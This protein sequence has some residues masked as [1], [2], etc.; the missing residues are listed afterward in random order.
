MIDFATIAAAFQA[1]FAV[2]THGWPTLFDHMDKL[3]EKLDEQAGQAER[4]TRAYP[5]L[6]F[7]DDAVGVRLVLGNQPLFVD[8]T[9]PARSLGEGLSDG[10]RQFAAGFGWV[11]DAVASELALPRTATALKE[12][13]QAVDASLQRYEQPFPAMFDAGRHLVDVFGMAG[14]AWRALQGDQN[15]DQIRGAAL[16]AAAALDVA[17]ALTGGDRLAASATGGAGGDLTTPVERLV[18]SLEDAA[19]LTMDAVLLLPVAGLALD[20]ALTD[21]VLAVETAML[22]AFSGLEAGVYD[23]RAGVVDAWLRA[24]ALGT[25]VHYLSAAADLVATLDVLLLSSAVPLWLNNLLDGVEAVLHGLGDWAGWTAAMARAFPVAA[26][27]LMAVDLMPWIVSNAL[28]PWVGAHV[29]LPSFTLD[30]LV[31]LVTGEG[32]SD[33]RDNLDDFFDDLDDAL[34]VA[35]FVIDVKSIRAKAAALA[36]VLHMTLTPTPFTYPPDV[37]PTGPLAGFPDVYAAL[38]GGTGRADL[39]DAVRRSGTELQGAVHTTLTAAQGLAAGLASGAEEEMR[40]QARMGAGLQLGERFRAEGAVVGSLFAPLRADL[41]ARA[42]ATPADPLATAFD[43]AVGATGIAAA[44]AAVPAYVTQMRRIWAASST[45]REYPTSAH[46]LAR[47]GRLSVVRVPRL[48]VQAPDWEPEHPLAAQTADRFRGVVLDA[49][50]QGR[51]RVAV[52]ARPQEEQRR[53]ARPAGRRPRAG[54]RARGGGSG[55]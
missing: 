23:L 52:L 46:L 9:R 29:P 47:R 44:A 30:D 35:D 15:Q 45:R 5:V 33:L 28:S 38:F 3:V 24:F 25:D 19:A 41:V 53:D 26:A 39:L 2:Q 13:A 27:D 34:W 50:R 14:L 12:M 20:A 43:Q 40:R 36:T 54:S 10:A 42:A 37:L 51:D 22:D 32:D 16:R 18:A 4:A 1:G 49:Y 48:T 8:P 31:T 11:G 21:G 17:R 55:G 6:R 7:R